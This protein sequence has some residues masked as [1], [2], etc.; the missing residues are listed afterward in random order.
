MHHSEPD[1][2]SGRF[3]S[4]GAVAYESGEFYNRE[5]RNV[6]IFDHSPDVTAATECA[7]GGTFREDLSGGGDAFGTNRAVTV[8]TVKSQREP[9]KI[10]STRSQMTGRRRRLSARKAQARRSFDFIL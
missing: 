8:A 3:V 2:V 7:A 6:G 4:S 10:A 1:I 5:I 9:P